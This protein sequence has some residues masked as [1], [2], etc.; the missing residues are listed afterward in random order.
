MNYIGRNLIFLLL[1]IGLTGCKP[2]EPK[3]PTNPV[4]S[5]PVEV[6]QTEVTKPAVQD[7]AKEQT[8]AE[9]KDWLAKLT[10]ETNSV[11]FRLRSQNVWKPVELDMTFSRFD[12]IQTK[13]SSTAEVIYLSGSSLGIK[14]NTLLIFDEDPGQKKKQ[15]DRVIVKSGR[16][17]AKTKTE[18]WVF[19]DSGLIQIKARKK[20]AQARIEVKAEN[21]K[22]SV[23]SGLAEVIYK[24]ENDFVRLQVGENSDTT[25]K[26]E[27]KIFKNE[28]ID[29]EKI[30]EIVIASEVVKPLEK[31]KLEI[32]EPK[33]NELTAKAE[34]TVKGRVTA[35]GA[36]ILLNGE[37]L[38]VA[39][40]LT[41]SKT[42]N[43]QPGTNLLVF[44]LVRSD[45]SIEFVKRNLRYKAE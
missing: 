10:K 45:S 20:P 6:Q 13:S 43:L 33:E 22:V 37:L 23:Q 30:S 2:D 27:H 18:L 12:A 7:V 38:E 3:I 8:K 1:V 42:I 40:D 14:E 44:Q 16:L 19:T 39:T 4:S 15:V 34:Y 41:F 29:T 25:I 26:S 9:S 31:A 24:K 35:P 11:E 21:V 36:K 5:P 32:S 28:Q 17:T